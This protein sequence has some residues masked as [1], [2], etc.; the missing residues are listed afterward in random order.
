[1]D[2]A[3]HFLQGLP[4]AT[5]VRALNVF[6]P[7]YLVLQRIIE[8]CVKKIFYHYACKWKS[9][10]ITTKRRAPQSQALLTEVT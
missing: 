1:M 10:Q 4:N 5:I 6:P 9:E 8:N 7:A 2:A 3:L